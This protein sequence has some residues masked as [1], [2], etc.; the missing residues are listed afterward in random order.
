M[1]RN[2]D[3]ERALSNRSEANTAL[4]QISSL[5]IAAKSTPEKLPEVIIN[6]F[7]FRQLCDFKWFTKASEFV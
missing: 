1:M 7:E 6:K 2:T 5:A 3:S 4:F